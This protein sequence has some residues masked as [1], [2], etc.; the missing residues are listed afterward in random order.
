MDE[1]VNLRV[2]PRE[3]DNTRFGELMLALRNARGYSRTRAA[4]FL[5]VSSEYI[6]TIE[7]GLRAP[8]AETMRH[9]LETYNIPFDTDLA[10]G[11]PVLI[12]EGHR[13]E[14]ASRIKARSMKGDVAASF[15]DRDKRI[16]QI[17]RL[18]V[19]TDDKTL[20]DIHQKLR[21]ETH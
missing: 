12:F 9:F 4:Y 10:D 15:I 21:R 3:A 13:V 5:E 8:A 11:N 19:G 17:I 2:G 6:R 1:I 18:L 16:G 20:A 14:F 7:K